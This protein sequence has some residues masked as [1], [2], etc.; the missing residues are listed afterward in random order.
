MEYVNGASEPYSIDR[1]ISVTIVTRDHLQNAG[2]EPF[3]RLHITVLKTD[4]GLVERK[5]HMVL[6]ITRKFPEVVPARSNPLNGLQILLSHIYIMVDSPYFCQNIRYAILTLHAATC[7]RDLSA[8]RSNR[9][10]N[11]KG[12]REG[13][14]SMRINR[15]WRLCFRWTAEGAEDVEIVD[16][17]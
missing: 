3:Q 17:H 2:P 7:L 14:Y 11:L 1:S 16:Y 8:L 13:Q 15:Q 10:E 4:L 5:T 6:Y 9:F 12:G